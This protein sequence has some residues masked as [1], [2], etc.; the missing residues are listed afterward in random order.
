MK[1]S[2]I[3]ASLTLAGM[4]FAANAVTPGNV[5]VYATEQSQG[6]VSIGDKTSYTKTFE[7]SIANLS[8]DPVD[9][10]TICLK[11]YTPDNKE[12]KID[13]VDEALTTGSLKQGK[14]VK[15]IAVFADEQDVVLK[16]ALVK[17]SD[18][19]K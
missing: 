18:E 5:A 17:I 9:L 8:G 1:F 11:A 3:V 15:G 13:T 2:T 7:V 16:A 4:G 10:S 14:P 12:F 6:S 19:C